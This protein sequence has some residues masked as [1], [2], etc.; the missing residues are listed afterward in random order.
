[1]KFKISLSI[2]LILCSITSRANKHKTVNNFIDS[3]PYNY[4]AINNSPINQLL[5]VHDLTITSIDSTSI[6]ELPTQISGEFHTQL[7]SIE[8]GVI[9]SDNVSNWSKYYFQ[10]AVILH[11]YEKFN[12]SLMANI[13]QLNNV[14]ALYLFNNEEQTPYGENL[15]VNNETKLNYSWGLVGSYSINSTWQFSGGVIRAEAF[16]EQNSNTWYSDTN[17]ALIGTT[18]SF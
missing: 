3:K 9:Q 2:A 16:R 4:L 10:G 12:L 11:Q 8:A 13:E 5:F 1:M 14:H 15:P 18:Y 17:M 7:L 6:N